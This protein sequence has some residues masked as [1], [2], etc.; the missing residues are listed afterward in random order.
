MTNLEIDGERFLQL[1]QVPK[2]TFIIPCR[3]QAVVNKSLA[4][5][6]ARQNPPV[7]AQSVE[8][9]LEK[10]FAE[11]F[12]MAIALLPTVPYKRKQFKKLFKT[13][14]LIHLFCSL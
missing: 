9:Y 3:S 8:E 11:N 13:F 6:R 2:A 10:V 7:A 12:E 14:S 5:H 1:F 4:I